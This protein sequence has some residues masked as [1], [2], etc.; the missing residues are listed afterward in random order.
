MW[1]SIPTP[2][3]PCSYFYSPYHHVKDCPTAGQFSNDFYEHM[4]T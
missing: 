3:G 2:H 4:N 1:G